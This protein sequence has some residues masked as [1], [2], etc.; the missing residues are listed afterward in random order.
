MGGPGE[1]AGVKKIQRPLCPLG[2]PVS[3]HHFL[4]SLPADLPDTKMSSTH[5]DG[6]MLFQTKEPHRDV[7]SDQLTYLPI[8]RQLPKGDSSVQRLWASFALTW[9]RLTFQEHQK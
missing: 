4:F 6:L 3:L 8:L 2:T 7:N 1:P 9:V 5:K